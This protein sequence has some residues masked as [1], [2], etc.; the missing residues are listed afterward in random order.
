M[1]SF[2]LS[3]V[4]SSALHAV[5]NILPSRCHATLVGSEGMLCASQASIMTARITAVLLSLQ[6]PSDEVEMAGLGNSAQAG[7]SELHDL[8]LTAARYS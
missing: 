5:V 1:N 7:V 3:L 8:L 4:G 6:R 2:S